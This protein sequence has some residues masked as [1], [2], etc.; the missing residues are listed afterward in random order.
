MDFLIDNLFGDD[1]YLIIDNKELALKLH[2][3][4]YC[5]QAGV[6]RDGGGDCLAFLLETIFN[7]IEDG[8]NKRNILLN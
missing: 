4:S 7:L 6:S 8:D 5:V 2:L 3:I 1:L